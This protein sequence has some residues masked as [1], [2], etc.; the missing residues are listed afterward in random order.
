MFFKYSQTIV[1]W[2][3]IGYRIHCSNK[4]N[5]GQFRSLRRLVS[6]SIGWASSDDFILFTSERGM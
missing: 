4:S 1:I 2:L 3:V 5:I 6:W